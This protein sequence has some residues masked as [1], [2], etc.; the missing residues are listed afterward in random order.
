MT[1]RDNDFYRER[2]F[3]VKCK[4]AEEAARTL[5]ELSRE[6]GWAGV[7]AKFIREGAMVYLG[8]GHEQMNARMKRDDDTTLPLETWLKREYFFKEDH[9]PRLNFAGIK[10]N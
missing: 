6:M 8:T 9:T 10:G 4:N 5:A 7:D 1:E 3:S 2:Q